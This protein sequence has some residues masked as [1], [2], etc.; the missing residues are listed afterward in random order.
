MFV[1]L[2]RMED[3]I[4][5]ARELQHSQL[6]KQINSDEFHLVINFAEKDS[7]LIEGVNHTL[8]NIIKNK[9]VELN[10]DAF[11][12]IN[13][14]LESNYKKKI[15]F[16]NKLNS[17]YN[18]LMSS[19]KEYL[20]SGKKKYSVDVIGQYDSSYSTPNLEN[21]KMCNLFESLAIDIFVNELRQKGWNPIIKGI[22][23][24]KVDHNDGM[25]SGGN[26]VTITCDFD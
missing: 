21:W 6:S 4:I 18:L 11:T 9:L 10:K 13:N 15:W 8:L 24:Y 1:R 3:F 26:T 2:K 19:L 12:K 14:I 5:P 25:Y 22:S 7:L 17:T 20:T 16:I 23:P